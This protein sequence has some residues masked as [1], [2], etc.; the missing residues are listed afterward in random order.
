MRRRYGEENKVNM[1]KV[2]ESE[3]ILFVEPTL[4]LV[5]EYLVMVNDIENVAKYISD[6]RDL[7]TE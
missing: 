1:N 2:F 4:E 3:R 7:Y 6:R 5:P